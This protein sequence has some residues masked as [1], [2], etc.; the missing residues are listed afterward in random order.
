MPLLELKCK[1][2]GGIIE[3]DDSQS[4][5]VCKYCNTQ[6]TKEELTINQ[7]YYNT[8]VIFNDESSVES[9]LENAE[10]YLTKINNYEKARDIFSRVIEQKGSDYRGWWGK[11]RALTEEFSLEMCSEIEYKEIEK[12][13]DIAIKL[14]DESLKDELRQIWKPYNSSLKQNIEKEQLEEQKKASRKKRNLIIRKSIGISVSLIS[15]IVMLSG[16]FIFDVH[17]RAFDELGVIIAT[18]IALA[19]N[20]IVTTVF[21]LL[22]KSKLCAV[23]PVVTSIIT[24]VLLVHGLMNG[25]VLSTFSF[26]LG[27]IVLCVLGL[28]AVGICGILPAVILSKI[29]DIDSFE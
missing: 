18:L 27:L 22:A 20:A 24:V 7:N 2:C 21:G 9:L 26:V 17:S 10:A 4:T 28:I 25:A 5:A 23:F 11:L 6:Y 16:V 8:T 14:A 15:N 1:N 12:C 19:A 13:A 3:Y 29:S